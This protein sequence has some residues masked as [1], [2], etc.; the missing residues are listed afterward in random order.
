MSMSCLKSSPGILLSPVAGKERGKR[1]PPHGAPIR[2]T[3]L[4]FTAWCAERDLP[5]IPAAP[6]TVAAFLAAEAARGIKPASI[7]SIFKMMDV[8]SHKS[9]DTL[10]GYVRDAELFRD[11]AGVGA[12][13][14]VPPT[15]AAQVRPEGRVPRLRAS[16]DSEIRSAHKACCPTGAIRMVNRPRTTE[17]SG[18]LRIRLGRRRLFCGPRRIIFPGPVARRLLG[19]SGATSLSASSHPGGRRRRRRL[20]GLDPGAARHRAGIEGL[21]ADP[22]T[23]IGPGA[24][25][26]HVEGRGTSAASVLAQRRGTSR[27]ATPRRHEAPH[28]WWRPLDRGGTCCIRGND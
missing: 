6:E 7:A 25:A 9:M 18:N 27:V 5:P 3:S 28:A 10:R 15:G 17:T 16:K 11:H 12:A 19:Q 21:A 1:Q 20:A 2:R 26:R 14:S 13:V 4:G 24:T 23:G 8:S 22:P